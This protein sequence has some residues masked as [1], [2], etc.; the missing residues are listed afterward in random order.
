L[1][2]YCGKQN[3]A[4]RDLMRKAHLNGLPVRYN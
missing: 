4:I 1:V 2:R 3:K